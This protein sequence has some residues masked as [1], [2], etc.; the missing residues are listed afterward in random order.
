MS[1]EITLQAD[2]KEAPFVY[3]EQTILD[4][5]KA[6]DASDK[7][8]V[9]SFK[10]ELALIRKAK[11]RQLKDTIKA[12][13]NQLKEQQTTLLGSFVVDK[14]DALKKAADDFAKISNPSKKDK[15]D[16][17]DVQK[18]IEIS[19]KRSASK[20]KGEYEKKIQNVKLKRSELYAEYLRVLAIRGVKENGKDRLNER[21]LEAYGRFNLKASLTN[22]KFWIDKVPLFRLIIIIAAY[23]IGK[24]ITGYSGSLG[25]VINNGIFVAVV[26]TGAV[27][28]YSQG[29]FDMSLGNASLRCAVIAAILYNATN[30]RVVSLLVSVVLGAGLGIV[31]A[32]L[33]TRLNLP[34]MVMTLT[35]RNILA[36][37]SDAI[38]ENYGGLITVSEGRFSNAWVYA[39]FLVIFFILCWFIFNYTKVGRRNKFIGSNKKAAKFNGINLRKSGR[40]SFALSGIGLGICGF[41]FACSKTGNQF[42]ASTVLGQVGLNVVIAIVFGGRTT[43]G[44][45]KS[46]VSCAIIGAFFSVFLDEFF[47]AISTP[48]FQVGDYCYRFKGLIFLIVSLANRWDTRGKML[49]SGG[50]I[51]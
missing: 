32:I 36:A 19:A 9:E 22:K 51:Q 23:Y 41:L 34:V 6:V 14:N 30:N 28:I 46:K 5:A 18:G 26:A 38:F 12:E 37:I 8:A 21:Y 25:D 35:R 40:I 43:S 11:D 45:P 48:T 29:G 4:Q 33:A 7:N 49:A 47:A 15:Q 3:F 1:I 10:K 16:Y 50:S 39:S 13:L 31:N 24:A 42:G 20:A 2:E 44:G 27:F 17:S